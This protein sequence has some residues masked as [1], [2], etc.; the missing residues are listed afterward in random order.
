[1]RIKAHDH[2][3]TLWLSARDT[4]AWAT[5]PG[6]RWPCSTLAD[7]RVVVEVDRNGLCGLAIDGRDGDCDGNE[8]DAIVSDHLPPAARRFWPT[9]EA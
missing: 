3:Y 8:L 7:H 5:R 6:S 4:H 1:M 9:W 2:G